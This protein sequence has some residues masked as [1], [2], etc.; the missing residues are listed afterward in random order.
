MLTLF[1]SNVKNYISSSVSK[2][3]LII[4]QVPE[5]EFKK[6]IHVKIF[7]TKPLGSINQCLK[8]QGHYRL[9]M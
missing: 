1:N 5:G 6:P 9:T 4:T 8:L 7:I 2:W 3:L